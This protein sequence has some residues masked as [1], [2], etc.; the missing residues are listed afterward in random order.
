MDMGIKRW[1]GIIFLWIAALAIRPVPVYAA[2]SPQN[3]AGSMT[4]PTSKEEIVSVILPTAAEE[5]PLD[6]FIDP[7]GLIYDTGAAKYGGGNVEKGAH[8][9]FHNQNGGEYDFS[10][11][12]DPFTITNQ[13][14]VPVNVTVTAG[15][16]DPGDILVTGSRDF[17]EDQAAICMA[18][19]DDEGNERVLPADGEIS[20][21]V[22][23]R[24]ASMGAY[25]YVYD[26]NVGEYRYGYL[27]DPENEY[28]DTYSFGLR[29]DCNVSDAWEGISDSPEVTVTWEVEPVLPEQ[30]GD[31]AEGEGAALETDEAAEPDAA[32]EEPEEDDG[33]DTEEF[34]DRQD[35]SVPDQD[36]EKAGEGSP[37]A[38]EDLPDTMGD[39]SGTNDS[40]SD[41]ENEPPDTE[42]GVQ[43]TV[44]L[45]GVAGQDKE[46]AGSVWE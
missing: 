36:E 43:K 13:S 15:I 24:A 40:L 21:T 28:F 10:S 23:M 3:A 41:A 32:V 29:A 18:L 30:A 31:G 2:E 6:F 39:P 5:S 45:N 44:G 26:E 8:I 1:K 16:E 27:V 11:Q 14:T 9:L 17:P 4:L 35:T 42:G 37:D 20:V 7:Q 25:S 22:S 33:Q 34:I 38:E 46:S 19:L 12:S